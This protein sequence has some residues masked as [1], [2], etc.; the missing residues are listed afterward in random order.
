MPRQPSTAI[1]AQYL[2]LIAKYSDLR[3]AH[4]ELKK[5]YKD[6]MLLNAE[7]QKNKTSKA[8]SGLC[9]KIQS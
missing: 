2:A 6:L 3:E 8:A 4:G 5:M 9:Q 7:L 1:E